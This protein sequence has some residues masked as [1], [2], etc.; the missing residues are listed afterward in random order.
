MVYYTRS[1]RKHLRN[2]ISFIGYV[3]CKDAR[4]F[5]FLEV[6]HSSLIMITFLEAMLYD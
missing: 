5:K 2:S 4:M 1:C 6:I 3:L